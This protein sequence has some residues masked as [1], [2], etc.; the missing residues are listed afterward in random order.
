MLKRLFKVKNKCLS[1][2]Y[3]VTK[4]FNIPQDLL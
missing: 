4:I 2:T 3:I 1:L